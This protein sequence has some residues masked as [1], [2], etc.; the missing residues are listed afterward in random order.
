MKRLLLFLFLV[1][2]GGQFLRAQR[3]SVPR[4]LAPDPFAPVADVSGLPRVLLIGDSISQGYTVPV[5]KLLAGKANVHRIPQNGGSTKTGVAKIEE[6]L[7]GG[8]PVQQPPASQAPPRWDV[9]HFNWGLHDLMFDPNAQRDPAQYE[10]DQ[11]ALY[12]KN[13][14]ALVAR[15]KETRA[16]LIWASSTPVPDE[17]SSPRSPSHRSAMVKTYNDVAAKVMAENGVPI[18]DLNAYVAPVVET[19]RKP[20]DVH[21]GEEGYE[22]LA[23]KV[24]EEI[25]AEL[26]AVAPQ[27]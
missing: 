6:W 10:K 12:E 2:A 3:P 22:F 7:G 5:Q 17:M 16:K 8:L 27:R 15:L 1:L 26:P 11:L 13:L 9:I 23:K 18:D 21:F 4:A 24:A 19:M 20:H 14:R 25:A